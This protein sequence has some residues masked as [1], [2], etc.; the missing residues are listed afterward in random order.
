MQNLAESRFTRITPVY[1]IKFGNFQKNWTNRSIVPDK[2]NFEFLDNGNL[3]LL[4]FLPLV[5]VHDLHRGFD[6]PTKRC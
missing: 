3:W 1:D 6:H 5:D 4:V 2:H